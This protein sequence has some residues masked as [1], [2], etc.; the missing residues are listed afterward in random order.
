MS[1]GTLTKRPN[2]QLHYTPS[3][4]IPKVVIPK[5]PKPRIETVERWKNRL[6]K[7]FQTDEER[8]KSYIGSA[9]GRYTLIATDGHCALLSL[10]DL[11]LTGKSCLD[12]TEDSLNPRGEAQLPPEFQ[13]VVKRA[14]TM[15]PENSRLV[16]VTIHATG[17]TV[18]SSNSQYGTFEEFL[19]CPVKLDKGEIQIGFN[20]KYLESICGVWPMTMMFEREDKQVVFKPCEELQ[21]AIMPMRA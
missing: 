8:H 10:T 6:V 5:E 12:L 15:A 13:L 14:L 11:P 21:A 2:G 7:T 1:L 16:T 18:T 4:A 3:N 19:E 17:I 9:S 20:G